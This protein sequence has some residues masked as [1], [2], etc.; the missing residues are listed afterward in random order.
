MRFRACPAGAC[1]GTGLRWWQR[2]CCV[3]PE[4]SHAQGLKPQDCITPFEVGQAHKYSFARQGTCSPRRD[5]RKSEATCTEQAHRACQ[6][7]EDA[8]RT[9][10]KQAGQSVGNVAHVQRGYD[11]SHH[12]S[13]GLAIAFGPGL[14]CRR[15]AQKARPRVDLG[16]GDERSNLLGDR[17]PAS[18]FARWVSIKRYG[19]MRWHRHHPREGCLVEVRRRP[20]LKTRSRICAI[21]TC[22]V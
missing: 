12:V 22:M 8:G 18:C 9:S 1:A 10:R 6:C 21:S 13:D 7:C 5:G 11:R 19:L 17:R 14:L 2:S 20:P 3:T 16:S 15:G 4:I